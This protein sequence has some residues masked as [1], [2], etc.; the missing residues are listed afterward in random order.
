MSDFLKRIADF[1][2]KRLLLLA[3]E[4]EERVRLL[5]SREH[6]PIAIIGIGCRFPGGVHD[7]QSYW[8]LLSRGVDAV[9]EVPRSRW[10]ADALY[11]PDAQALG[12][13]ASRWCGFIESAECFDPDFFGIAPVEAESMDPQQRLLL[14]VTWEALEDALIPPATLAGTRT[15]VFAGLCNSDYAQRTLRSNGHTIDAYF[16]QGASHAVASGRISYFLGLRGPS[17]SIDTACSSSLVAVHQAVQSLRLAETDVALAGGVNL[18]CSPEVSI[19]LSR[20]QM[21]ASDGRCKAFSEDADGFVR[22]E[23][24]GIVVLKRLVDAERAGDR[25][26]AVIRGSAVNQDGRSSGI[27]AP[28]GPSQEDVVRAALADAALKPHQVG[29]VEAHGTG[30]KLGDPI[31]LRALDAAY[32]EGRPLGRRLP[33]GS[34]KTNI[35]HAEAAAGIAGV[36]KLALSLRRKRILPNLHFRTPNPEVEWATNCLRVPVEEE[37]WDA[38]GQAQRYG[39]VSSFGFSGTNAHLILSDYVAN[40]VQPESPISSADPQIIVL[41]AKSE[42]ALFALAASLADRVTQDPT[43]QLKDVAFSL[44]VGRTP[45]AHRA[46]LSAASMKE[47]VEALRLLAKGDVEQTSGFVRGVASS[48]APRI[49]FLFA[50]QGGEHA[51]MGL[52]LLK[53]SPVFRESVR[54]VDQALEGVLDTSVE[55]IFRNQHDELSR[56]ALVQPALFAFQYGVSRIWRSWGIEPNIVV[57]H[58]MGEI[59]AATL[60]GILTL[61]DAV[62]LIAARGRTTGE[63]GE[64]GGMVAVAA[65]EAEALIILEK[66][67]TDVSIAAINGPS[68]LVISGRRDPLALATHKFES[69]GFRVKRLAISYGSHSPAMHRV[70]PAFYKEAA[71]F[72]YRTPDLPIIA[73]LTGS[74]VDEDSPLNAQ[75]FTSHLARP[76]QFNRCLERLEEERIG[77]C[78]EM[79]PR[80]VLTTFGKERNSV[81]TRWVASASGRDPDWDSLLRAV[82]EAF[83]AGASIDWSAFFDQTS[84]HKVSLPTYPFE[85]ERYWI[86]ETGQGC[87][88]LASLDRMPSHA[89]TMEPLGIAGK[90]LDASLPVFSLKLAEPFPME[91]SD[92]RIGSQV[93]LPASY[94]LTLAWNALHVVEPQWPLAKVSSLNIARSLQP[95]GEPVELQTVLMAAEKENSVYEFRIHSRRSNDSPWTLHASGTLDGGKIQV[96]CA[97]TYFDTNAALYLTGEQFYEMLTG[98]DVHVSGAFR[99]LK[100]L[101]YC[102]GSA[103]GKVT[104]L[105]AQEVL[106]PK[107]IGPPPALLDVCFQLLGAASLLATDTQLRLVTEIGFIV[108]FERLEGELQV[109]AKV[110]EKADHASEGTIWIRGPRSKLLAI[111]TGILLRPVASQVEQSTVLIS[112]SDERKPS[113]PDRWQQELGEDRQEALQRLVRREAARVLGYTADRLPPADARLSELGLD[114]LMAVNLRNRLQA[115][116]G[117]ALP[118][119]FAFE[120]PTTSQMA[121]AIDLLFWTR[122][123]DDRSSHA[124]RDEIQI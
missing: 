70:L 100:E 85:R 96:P 14:E 11:D 62:T 7:P 89:S 32:K 25:I 8:D 4:L 39:A 15:G 67:S 47:L 102:P 28:N 50:G 60:A 119:T 88:P 66:F 92:H 24:C 122:G 110:V 91:L 104:A 53:N 109:E 13:I 49:A 22:S 41:S 17:L 95:G 83:C 72:T 2:P 81:K 42:R 20:A 56:S 1:S 38:E 61:H 115:V 19:A 31:E 86:S 75:Y 16:A 43:I 76:V 40:D 30:T 52:T 121:A 118:P 107:L 84:A 51:G 69:S 59:V 111:A 34:V 44:A 106:R 82:A 98:K 77:L 5:E 18:L 12:R 90:R 97:E 105:P 57:G 36:I 123:L 37:L 63:L 65:T 23:G 48:H 113:S 79:G 10:D 35:G 55:S 54:E 103:L 45:F 93:V 108:I 73:D 6:A 78:I 46:A 114:S 68:S 117:Q 33:V 87:D 124:E 120:H 3:A 9:T 101:W 64:E 94:F 116:T 27:T 112:N 74:M 99:G 29:Y 21:M 26:I 80:A 71:R 58:S